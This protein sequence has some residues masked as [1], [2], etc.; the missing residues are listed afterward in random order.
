MYV[1]SLD[2]TESSIDL[3]YERFHNREVVNVKR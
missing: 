2:N 1:Y 3:Q